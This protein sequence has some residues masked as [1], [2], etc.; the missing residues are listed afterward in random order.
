[1]SAAAVFS[2]LYQQ[3][4]V[5]FA[6]TSSTLSSCMQPQQAGHGKDTVKLSQSRFG[7]CSNFTAPHHC[8]QKP[9]GKS[10]SDEASAS[11]NCSRLSALARLCSMEV[12]CTRRA[13]CLPSKHPG[14]KASPSVMLIWRFRTE[15]RRLLWCLIVLAAACT[16]KSPCNPRLMQDIV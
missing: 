9:L 5:A 3:K 4:L 16:P 7:S 11:A 12:V 2:F 15:A 8:P 14:Q 13:L 6:G 1:M 10:H